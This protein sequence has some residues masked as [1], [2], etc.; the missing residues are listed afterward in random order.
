MR[1]SVA[2]GGVLREQARGQVGTPVHIELAVH[3]GQVLLD[4]TFASIDELPNRD[5]ADVPH[6]LMSE[7]RTILQGT[8]ADLWFIHL[9]HSNP[10]LVNGTDV[11]REGMTLDL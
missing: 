10:A 11:V 4:G 6:P 5:I 7:T 1:N 9:N 3:L 8:R 2:G